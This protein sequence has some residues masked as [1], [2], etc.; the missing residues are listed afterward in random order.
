MQE[1]VEIANT[2]LLDFQSD[3]SG[4]LD[5]NTKIKREI[6]ILK[7]DNEHLKKELRH[8]KGEIANLVK[9]AGSEDEDEGDRMLGAWVTNLALEEIQLWFEK[10]RTA[11]RE[12]EKHLKEQLTKEKIQQHWKEV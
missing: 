1:A 2:T 4:V 5:Q 12:V 3:F 6:T 9:Q 8:A 11:K 10:E 7:N